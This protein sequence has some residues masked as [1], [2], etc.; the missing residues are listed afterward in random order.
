[1]IVQVFSIYDACACSYN[2]PFYTHNIPM[3]IR[4]VVRLLKRDADFR[5]NASECVLYHLGSFDDAVGRFTNLPEAVSLGVVS[6][7]VSRQT[8]AD[9]KLIGTAQREK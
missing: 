1:M 3:A 9:E 8:E 6:D 7:W 5:E 2:R 4:E